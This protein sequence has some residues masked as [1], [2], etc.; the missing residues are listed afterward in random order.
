MVQVAQEREDRLKQLFDRGVHVLL[1]LVI[2]CHF[3]SA[4]NLVPDP[5]SLYEMVIDD[6]W[7]WLGRELHRLLSWQAA[8]LIFLPTSAWARSV[9][10]CFHYIITSP[11]GVSALHI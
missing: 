8:S 7:R 2:D 1:V 5:F 3:D 11:Q 10:P 4:G 9:S 6:W